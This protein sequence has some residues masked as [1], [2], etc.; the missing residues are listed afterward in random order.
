MSVQMRLRMRRALRRAEAGEGLPSVLVGI[1]LIILTLTA[2]AVAFTTSIAGVRTAEATDRATQLATDRIEQLRDV[3]WAQVGFYDNDP[4][5]VDLPCTVSET[6]GTATEVERPVIL[7]ATRPTDGTS[8]APHPLNDGLDVNGRPTQAARDLAPSLDFD[9][10]KFRVQTY[11]TLA[12]NSTAIYPLKRITV[13]INP[14]GTNRQIITST[15]RAPTAAE[16]VPLTVADANLKGDRTAGLCE[17]DAAPFCNLWVTS[18]QVLTSGPLG[19]EASTP[20]T[21]RAT[22][23]NRVDAVTASIPGISVPVRLVATNE[24]RTAWEYTFPTREQATAAGKAV[25][26]L[27]LGE[28]RITFRLGTTA[29]APSRIYSDAAWRATA[30]TA[31]SIRPVTGT[32]TEWTSGSLLTDAT[33]TDRTTAAGTEPR[34]SA[35]CVGADG[36]LVAYQ[37]LMFDVTGIDGQHANGAKPTITYTG[38]PTGGP[39]N[40]NVDQT[41]INHPSAP[42]SGYD[43]TTGYLGAAPSGTT[44]LGTVRWTAAFARGTQFATTNGSV[45]L[46]V[47][48]TRP[49]D[50]ALLQQT[51]LIPVKQASAGGLCS[52]VPTPTL[53]VTYLPDASQ[54]ATA[55]RNATGGY[56]YTL[57]TATS[58]SGPWATV[59]TAMPVTQALTTA[60]VLPASPNGVRYYRVQARAADGRASD[61][62]DVRTL[63]YTP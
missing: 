34:A 12:R 22:T 14:I 46:T 49:L 23:L 15:L 54:G 47:A 57:Q 59:T 8:R 52:D 19:F 39:V 29:S 55:I 30:A 33:K 60:S 56:T 13:S 44:G 41:D 17:G 1:A 16:V 35:F 61:W 5:R 20:I 38:G 11:I 45:A 42:A 36:A 40:R 48:T 7:G 43:P 32:N 24:N 10:G 9:G 58:A 6:C 26:V 25:P 18:G 62:S 4:G 37:A 31:G 3:P 27:P 50:G 28:Q 21:L 63:T 2:S 53:R 51:V